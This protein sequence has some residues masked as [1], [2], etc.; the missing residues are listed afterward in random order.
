MSKHLKKLFIYDSE[1]PEFELN[2]LELW[3][4]ISV[5]FKCTTL[6]VNFLFKID[7]AFHITKTDAV[8]DIKYHSEP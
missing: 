4:N 7:R 8:V 5:H 6:S 2:Y 3:E 1:P